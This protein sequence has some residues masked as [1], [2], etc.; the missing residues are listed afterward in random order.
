M[1]GNVNS[2]FEW[3]KPHD[4]CWTTDGHFNVSSMVHLP[5]ANLDWNVMS[6]LHYEHEKYAGAVWFGGEKLVHGD[7]SFGHRDA[8]WWF[9]AREASL[10]FQGKKLGTGAVNLKLD[11]SRSAAGM[12]AVHFGEEQ[13]EFSTEAVVTWSDPAMF[14][15]QMHLNM[16]AN[17][18][19]PSVGTFGTAGRLNYDDQGR[20]SM[21]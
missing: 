1:L 20:W 4:R 10:Q 2:A 15:N 7:G 19:I 14:A 17:T 18:T 6:N 13:Q 3:H 9:S 5:F 8:M 16:A 12:M 11:T 21:D